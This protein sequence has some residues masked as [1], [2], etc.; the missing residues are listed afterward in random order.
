[1][2]KRQLGPKI[3]IFLKKPHDLQHEIAMQ[4]GQSLLP[5]VLHHLLLH[6]ADNSMVKLVLTHVLTQ[7][8]SFPDLDTR[9]VLRVTVSLTVVDNQ[10]VCRLR[11][12]PEAA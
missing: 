12:T 8:R 5:P 7:P 11:P 3:V 1:M 6:S 10:L 2:Q 9:A 4:K